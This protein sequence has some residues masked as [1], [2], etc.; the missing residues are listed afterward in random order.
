M[1]F[2]SVAW[3]GWSPLHVAMEKGFWDE[4]DL[5]VKVMNYDDPII[6]LEAIKAKKIDFAMD[7]VG[8]LVGVYM[9]GEPVVAIAET[10]WSHGGDKIVVRK[11]D[12]LK[13][14][15]GNIIGVFLDQPSCLF[16][17]GQYL[18]DVNLR[19]SHFRIVEI[20]ARDLSAQFIAK[21]LPAI[22]N[23]EPW[24]GEAV[25]K[26]KGVILATS[27]DYRGCIPECLWAYRPTVEDTPS[28][29]I[30]N[31]LKG[32]I[33]A[34]L[35]LKNPENRN[36]FFEILRK[37]TFKDIKGIKDEHIA[38]M[39]KEVR[40]HSLPDL[41][42]RNENMGGLFRYLTS[43]KSFLEKE[44]RLEKDFLPK[45]IFRNQY[46]MHVLEKDCENEE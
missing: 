4:L 15:I 24:V 2:R 14:N 5:D 20:N 17:L 29:D 35:W 46:I 41:K 45:T 7:M 18:K 3:I 11:G 22:V 27:A 6:I 23:Y 13:N 31:L 32:W 42:E 33:N 28:E 38:K 40:I 10:N 39:L 43:L 30:H 25:T 37:Q 34:V 16:F 21:R 26:G 12:R 19:L 8:S 44:N 36:E 9:K 1:L